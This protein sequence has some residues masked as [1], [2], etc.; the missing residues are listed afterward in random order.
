L[1]FPEEYFSEIYIY[2]DNS[3]RLVIKDKIENLFDNKEIM[4]E[5]FI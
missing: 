4:A 5:F 2:E 1:L 3:I